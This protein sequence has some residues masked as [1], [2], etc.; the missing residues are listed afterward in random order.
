M[1]ASFIVFVFT[2]DGAGGVNSVRAF[3]IRFTRAAQW[4]RAP[5]SCRIT[6]N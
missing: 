1:E 2:R 5:R 4:C 3:G 6:P